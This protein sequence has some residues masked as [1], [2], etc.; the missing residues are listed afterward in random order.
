M[1]MNRALLIIDMQVCHLP[2][3]DPPY[4]AQE[5][6]EVDQWLI[7]KARASGVPVI[8]VQHCGAQGSRYEPGTPG[9]QFHP[10]L[11]P[12]DGETVVQKRHPDSFQDTDLRDVLVSKGIGKLIVAGMRSEMCID[13]T[14]R[15]A[16]SLGYE[17][18]LVSDGHTTWST[19]VLAGE[20]IVAHH[21]HVLGYKFAKAVDHPQADL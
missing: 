9:W 5:V 4:R 13:T 18:E 15:R 1:V 17:V 14:V 3:D 2:V 16:Y 12:R 21:N 20:R 11:E 10:L 7:E 8:F 6:L 19:P